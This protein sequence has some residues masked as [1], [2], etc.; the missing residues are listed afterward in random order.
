MGDPDRV[1]F[2]QWFAEANIPPIHGPPPKYIEPEPEP[3]QPRERE[4]EQ[5]TLFDMRETPL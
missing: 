3:E 2:R 1:N 5:L 4:S